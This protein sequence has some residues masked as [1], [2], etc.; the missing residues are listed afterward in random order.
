MRRRKATT[1]VTDAAPSSRYFE[2]RRLLESRHRAVDASIRERMATVRGERATDRVG[3]QDDGEVS[4]VDVQEDIVLALVQLQRETQERIQ[5]ALARL[6]NGTYGFCSECGEDIAAARLQA[7]PFA[8]RCL[9]CEQA[10]ESELQRL[11]ARSR[12]SGTW[13]ETSI[14]LD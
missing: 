13:H 11:R 10:R 5:A 9:D 8:V 7:L 12:Q 2:L 3:A 1:G 6:E 4:E 14:R